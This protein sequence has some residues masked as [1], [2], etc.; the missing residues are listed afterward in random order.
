QLTRLAV[1]DGEIYYAERLLHRCKLVEVIQHDVRDRV[2]FQLDHDAHAFPI[3]FIPQVR[4][5]LELLVIDQLGNSFEQLGFID[6]IRNLGDHD[7]HSFAGASDA[8]YGRA[9]PHDDH[10]SAGG[11]GVVYALATVDESSGWKVGTGHH[12]HQF[13]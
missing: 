12:L 6:L 7:G 10:A 4:N 2:A 3:R 8:I 9:R 5:P 1:Y 13:F 11:V